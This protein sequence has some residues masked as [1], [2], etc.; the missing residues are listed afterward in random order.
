MTT[1]AA[2]DPV[3]KEHAY[4]IAHVPDFVRYGS[5]PFR[6]I[7]AQGDTLLD[8]IR[9]HLRGFEAAT[10]YPP[11]QVFVGNSSPEDLKRISKPWYQCTSMGHSR[12]GRFGEIMPEGEFYGV[13]KVADEFDLVWLEADFTAF[14][15]SQLSKHPLFNEQDLSRLGSGQSHADIQQKIKDEASLPLYYDS[16][17]VGCL[18]RHHA[19]DE[20]L[21]AR[22]LMENLLTKAS[23]GLAVRHLLHRAHMSADDVAYLLSCSEEA[24]GDRYNRGGG[25]LAKAIGEMCGCV[26]ATGSDVKAFCSGPIYALVHAASLVKAGVFE[27][28][29]VVGGGCMAKLGMKYQGHLSHDMPILEDILGAFAF[30]VGRND[31]VRP[32]LR[33][34][35]IGI[36]KIGAST[37]PQAV[38]ESLVVTPLRRLGLK[39]CDIDKYATELHNPEVTVPQGSGDVPLNNYRMIAALAVI[40]GEIPKSDLDRFVD[41]HG[42]PG[43]SPTQGHIPA[44]VPFLG[45]AVE[46]IMADRLRNAMFLAKGSLF[47][48]RMSHL[49]DGMSF[50]LEKN[51]PTTDKMRQE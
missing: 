38:M 43:F 47:L 6:D 21:F 49:S 10:A 31:G 42:M 20:S 9:R 40:N 5:K 30:L 13:L 41:E 33:L 17:L 45:H 15:R 19:E 37:S 32:V 27:N 18:H 7:A 11:N 16:M 28:V 22:V 3:I 44:G 4:V 12:Q 24:V 46:A 36:H 35:S 51:C 23:G 50:I 48:G 39:L 1:P 29:L 25:N 14:V 34:D 8:E 26:N 2:D